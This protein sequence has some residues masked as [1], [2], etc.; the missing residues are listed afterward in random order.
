MVRKLSAVT[1]EPLNTKVIMPHPPLQ[2]E[3]EEGENKGKGVK[4]EKEE[5]EGKGWQV[6]VLEGLEITGDPLAPTRPRDLHP[7][8]PRPRPHR[9]VHLLRDILLQQQCC[10]VFDN[11][12]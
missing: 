11:L 9:N 8:H 1:V 6:L 3:Q 4:E 7:P 10:L 5:D 12:G 2:E